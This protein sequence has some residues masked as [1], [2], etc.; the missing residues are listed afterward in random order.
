MCR[1][2]RKLFNYEPHASSEEVQSAALQYV[3]KIS[4][5]NKPS[6]I[7]AKAFNKAVLEIAHVST[8]LLDDLVTD[9]KP[10]NREIEKL[11]A[12]IRNA[13]RFK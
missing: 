5:F 3:R 7:N 2:I 6:Q 12:K 11:K 8:H 10:G 13:K 1:N 9:A 4:G